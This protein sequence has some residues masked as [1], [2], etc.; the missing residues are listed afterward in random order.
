MKEEHDEK[1]H[2]NLNFFIDF[3]GKH[4]HRVLGFGIKTKAQKLL[5]V[6]QK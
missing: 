4:Y 3:G 1:E 2:R 6:A 5:N